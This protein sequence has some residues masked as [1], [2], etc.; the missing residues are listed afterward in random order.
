MHEAAVAQIDA[1]V[2]CAFGIGL[3]ENKIARLQAGLCDSVVRL[4]IARRRFAVARSRYRRKTAL[5]ESRTVNAAKGFTAPY[6]WNAEIAK[7]GAGQLYLQSHDALGSGKGCL[8][9]SAGPCPYESLPTS[10]ATRRSAQ[11][12]SPVDAA[13]CS[14]WCLAA[15]T[16]DDACASRSLGCVSRAVPK[17]AE[18][19]PRPEHSHP[20]DDLGERSARRSY[21]IAGL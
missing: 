7:R 2:R 8:Q 12:Y 6:V 20:A 1:N 4:Q 18:S 15:A 16:N 11:A 17:Y 9:S 5:H 19:D 10:L 13:T 3:E 14:L 21:G